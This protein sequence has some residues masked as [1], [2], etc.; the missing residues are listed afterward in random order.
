M[1]GF[2]VKPIRLFWII[3]VLVSSLGFVVWFISVFY[4]NADYQ[5]FTTLF[6]VM[7][8]CFQF[9]LLAIIGEYIGK[10]FM[11]QNGKPQFVIKKTVLNNDRK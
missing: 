1:F 5:K 4:E 6:F 11:R 3:G 8:L 7:I 9:I 10:I 2:S